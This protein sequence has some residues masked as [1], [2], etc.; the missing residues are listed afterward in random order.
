[1]AKYKSNSKKANF[2]SSIPITSL[3]D[4]SNDL[5]LEQ[6]NQELEKNTKILSNFG[7]N[8]LKIGSLL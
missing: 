6:I 4:D 7:F 1:M 2:L 3:D 8:P 5:N